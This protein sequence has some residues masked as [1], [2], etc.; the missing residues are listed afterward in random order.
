MRLYVLQPH[1]FRC[2]DRRERFDLGYDD[3][4]DLQRRE[5]EVAAAESLA[6]GERR[7]RAYRDAVLAREEHRL[8]H[9]GRAPGVY[10]AGD[11]G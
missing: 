4:F 8:A 10:S 3:V 6:I 1:A 9:H 11:V 7:M 2:S 5:L